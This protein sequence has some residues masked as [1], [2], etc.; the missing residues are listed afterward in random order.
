MISTQIQIQNKDKA[1][2][3][4]CPLPNKLFQDIFKSDEISF[5]LLMNFFKIYLNQTGD[6]F[7]TYLFG[8]MKKIDIAEYK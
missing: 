4:I 3:D 7:Q 5:D 2:Q 8:E 1:T 6:T